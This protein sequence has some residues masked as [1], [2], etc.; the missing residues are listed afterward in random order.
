MLIQRRKER[1][2]R[3]CLHEAGEINGSGVRRRRVRKEVRVKEEW[4]D[5]DWRQRGGCREANIK[6]CGTDNWR[7][8]RVLIIA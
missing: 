8:S 7:L 1:A 3:R 4:P 5:P 6:L 2:E